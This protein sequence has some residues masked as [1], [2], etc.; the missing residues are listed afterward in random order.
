MKIEEKNH[1]ILLNFQTIDV[2][3]HEQQSVLLLVWFLAM[4]SEH[5]QADKSHD[6]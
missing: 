3:V 5:P 4:Y 6:R 1:H 2:R